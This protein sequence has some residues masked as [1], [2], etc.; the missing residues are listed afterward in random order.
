MLSFIMFL[1]IKMKSFRLILFCMLG[2]SATVTHVR[3][4]SEGT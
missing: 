3:D 1:G 4:V 2:P